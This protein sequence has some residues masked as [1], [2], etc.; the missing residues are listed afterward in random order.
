MDR[1]LGVV[2]AVLLAILSLVDA[3]TVAQALTG[4]WLGNQ[5]SVSRGAVNLARL[6]ARPPQSNI[7][8]PQCQKTDVLLNGGGFPRDWAKLQPQNQVKDKTLLCSCPARHCLVCNRSSMSIMQLHHAPTYIVLGPRAAT[9]PSLPQC[10]GF[11][12]VF[13]L[14]VAAPS[15]ILSAS[16]MMLQPHHP[17]PAAH[18]THLIAAAMAT[19]CSL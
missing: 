9:D 10:A 12:L 13:F 18:F 4:L 11:G 7:V 17:L 6:A 19:V 1:K 16:L 14:C 2:L 3:Q 15:V 5:G 8:L